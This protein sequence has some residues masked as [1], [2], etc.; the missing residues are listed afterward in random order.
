MRESKQL[1]LGFEAFWDFESE[2]AVSTESKIML[3]SREK[4]K[5]R[6]KKMKT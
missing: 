2:S 4:I 3:K 6:R 5:K 1:K